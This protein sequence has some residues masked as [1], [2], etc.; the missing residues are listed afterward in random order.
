M[1]HNFLL[2]SIEELLKE[3]SLGYIKFIIEIL[4]HLNLMRRHKV[5]PPIL[6]YTTR[7][8]PDYIA[9]HLENRIALLRQTRNPPFCF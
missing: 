8:L 2:E 4:S 3:I 1:L 7:K 5:A 9:K 6:F